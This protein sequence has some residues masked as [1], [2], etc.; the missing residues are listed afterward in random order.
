M[1]SW[2]NTFSD[3]FI[4][5]SEDFIQNQISYTAKC[6]LQNRNPTSVNAK[7]FFF[8]YLVYLCVMRVSIDWVKYLIKQNKIL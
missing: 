4:L 6:N 3:I 1:F 5:L 2:S 8:F 7:M